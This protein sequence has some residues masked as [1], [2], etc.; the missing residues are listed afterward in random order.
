MRRVLVSI[1]LLYQFVG[2]EFP[3]DGYIIE[4]GAAV[5]ATKG[6]H[7]IVFNFDLILRA[8]SF[9]FL[10]FRIRSHMAKAHGTKYNCAVFNCATESI[11]V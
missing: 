7:T 3:V 2:I 8:F 4:P 6:S 10:K 9:L 1:V 11:E 5:L